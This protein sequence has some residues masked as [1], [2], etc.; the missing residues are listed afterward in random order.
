MLAVLGSQIDFEGS[1]TRVKVSK[2]KES[3]VEILQERFQE[4]QGYKED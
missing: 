1:S 3:I 2:Q 4:E